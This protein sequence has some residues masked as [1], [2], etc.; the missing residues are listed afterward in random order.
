MTTPLTFSTDKTSSPH[1]ITKISVVYL[2]I[3]AGT[4]EA[5][6]LPEGGRV[7]PRYTVQSCFQSEARFRSEPFPRFPVG[8][9]SDSS[10]IKSMQH[11]MT[12]NEADRSVRDEKRYVCPEVRLGEKSQ[13]YH[14]KRE[15]DGLCELRVDWVNTKIESCFS[16]F[17]RA[18]FNSIIDKH[19]HMHFFTFKTVLV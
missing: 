13:W 12:Q 11:L 17:H 14:W 16:M 10:Q 6:F 4:L 3:Y 5:D 2:D 18:F 1:P 9:V 7:L 8:V 15:H 19:Q